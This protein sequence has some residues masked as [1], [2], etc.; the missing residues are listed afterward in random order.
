MS[1]FSKVFPTQICTVKRNIEGHTDP[2]TG[3]WVTAVEQLI[4][5]V[6][7]DIKP[8]SG[9]ERA[10]GLQTEY[11]NDYKAFINNQDITFEPGYSEIKKGDILIN[12]TG[13]NYTI[14]YPGKWDE[15]YICDLK[16]ND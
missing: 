10:T 7:A 15:H 8:K 14:V 1:V 9:R 5:T 13:K 4:A 11:E 16:E 12:A 2:N 3:Q 6:E